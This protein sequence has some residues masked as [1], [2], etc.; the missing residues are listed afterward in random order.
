[1]VRSN[2]LDS[3]MIL[4]M[5]RKEVWE[6]EELLCREFYLLLVL[7]GFC[8]YFH[9][10]TCYFEVNYFESILGVI[11]FVV[12]FNLL[13]MV[14]EIVR[15]VGGLRV[16]EHFQW[17]QMPSYR[18]W[19]LFETSLELLISSWFTLLK[20]FH[21][22]HNTLITLQSDNSLGLIIWYRKKPSCTMICCGRQTSLYMLGIIEMK[23]N[24]YH[25][26]TQ[27][28]QHLINETDKLRSIYEGLRTIRT[29][30]SILNKTSTYWTT[31]G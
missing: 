12:L 15:S 19:I 4:E 17:M 22:E 21:L 3:W 18:G 25:I 8:K 26:N 6:L 7:L 29:I 30:P 27:L 16:N 28:S 9:N 13:W 11:L 14:I 10:S 1:M 23:R 24:S 5:D 31:A 20:H 2:G